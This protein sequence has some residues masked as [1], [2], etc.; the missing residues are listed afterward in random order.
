MRDISAKVADMSAIYR[1]EEIN[2]RFCEKIAS[3]GN[4]SS[5]YQRL[6]DDKLPIF[7]RYLPFFMQRDLKAQITPMLIRQ[8]RCDSNGNIAIQWPDCSHILI[9]WPKLIFNG[10][11]MFQLLFWPKFHPFFAFILHLLSHYSIFY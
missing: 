2:R 9:Q 7:L 6:I 10:K 8:P 4:K 3:G 1:L 11:I 5:I